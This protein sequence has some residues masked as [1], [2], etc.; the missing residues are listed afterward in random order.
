[1]LCEK[2]PCNMRIR[3]ST[4]AEQNHSSIVSILG[5]GA[6]WS[7]CEHVVK[8]LERQESQYNKTC[9]TEDF[10]NVSAYN[11]KSQFDGEMMKQDKLARRTLAYYPYKHFFEKC[12]LQSTGLQ[13]EKMV[14]IEGFIVWPIDYVQTTLNSTIVKRGTRCKCQKRID[15]DIQCEHELT[16][17]PKFNH[18]HYNDCL[19]T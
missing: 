7:I 17:L 3:G 6:S 2:I 18:F 1:M 11:H 9:K 4:P 8:L 19:L 12:L 16:L 5:P 10:H 15:F 13:F 14:G